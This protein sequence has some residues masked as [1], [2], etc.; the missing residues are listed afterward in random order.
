MGFKAVIKTLNIHKFRPFIIFILNK[1]ST[2][3]SAFRLLL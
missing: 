1:T 3:S 2:Y